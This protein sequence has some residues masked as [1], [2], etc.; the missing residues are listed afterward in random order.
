MLGPRGT[1]S[2]IALPRVSIARRIKI[3]RSKGRGIPRDRRSVPHKKGDC[4]ERANLQSA[5]GVFANPL[6]PVV[7]GAGVRSIYV[8]TPLAE[9]ARPKKRDKRVG[10]P[11]E[12]GDYPLLSGIP[13]LLSLFVLHSAHPFSSVVFLSRFLPTPTTTS[14]EP[15][16]RAS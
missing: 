16:E 5:S 10:W 2:F 15:N 7:Y 9:L 12:D 1:P 4:C 6:S 11:A 13:S 3:F 8:K 14:P